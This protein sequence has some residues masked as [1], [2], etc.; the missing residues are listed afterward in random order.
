MGEKVLGVIK[1]RGCK[2]L[3]WESIFQIIQG[4][5]MYEFIKYIFCLNVQILILLVFMIVWMGDSF[6]LDNEKL[7]VVERG[8]ISFFQK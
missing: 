2:Y 6:F 3:M 5:Y 4:I 1:F 8:I 7:N